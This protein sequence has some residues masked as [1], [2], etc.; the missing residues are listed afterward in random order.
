MSGGAG[1]FRRISEREIH[2]GYIVRLTESTFVDPAG[3]EF[4]RDVVHTP[5]AVGIVPVDRGEGGG[6]DVVLVRQF[7]APL[8][9]LLLEI[10]AGMCDV[11]GEQ[12]EA[13]A[14]RELAEE[15]GYRA[16][17]LRPLTTFHPAAGFTT[18]RTAL[19]LGV[20]LDPVDRAADGVEEQHMTI[21]RMPLS[22]A[23][24]LV[25]GGEIT[26]AKTVIGLLMAAAR[27][28]G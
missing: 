18:H 4:R 15:A 11:D 13:T 3:E 19:V 10:P 21:E 1:G 2:R 12:V 8:E 23:L 7:R 28:E 9:S 26:D 27:L 22:Q 14:Q 25:E 6:W 20:G 17:V 24:D 16:R 5:N